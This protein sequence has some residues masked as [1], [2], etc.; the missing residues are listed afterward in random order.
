MASPRAAGVDGEQLASLRGDLR[1]ASSAIP[2][3]DLISAQRRFFALLERPMSVGFSI[4]WHETFLQLGPAFLDERFV[5]L[6]SCVTNFSATLRGSDYL[7]PQVVPH[8][9]LGELDIGMG[10]AVGRGPG[11]EWH[12][13]G[14]SMPHLE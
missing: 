14:P 8:V 12:V 5:M 4:G 6:P 2:A 3:D 10:F 9:T 1:I 11:L 7:S 13:S